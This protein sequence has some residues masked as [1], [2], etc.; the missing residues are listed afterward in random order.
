MQVMERNAVKIDSGHV[1]EDTQGPWLL[2]GA[3]FHGV[4]EEGLV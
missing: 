3:S 4:Q 1:S 2:F